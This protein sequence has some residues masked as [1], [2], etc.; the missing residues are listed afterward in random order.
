MKKNRLVILSLD[1]MV[2]ED[3]ETL[4]KYPCFGRLI[5]QGSRVNRIRTIYPSLTYP[6]HVSILTGVRPGR[7]G[8]VNNEPSIPGNLKC[9][10]YW[11]HEPVRSRDLH[12]AAKEAGLRTASIFWPASGSHP[13]VDYL[14]A[15]YWAQS[16]EDTLKAAYLRAGT[17]EELFESAVLPYLEGFSSWESPISDEAKICAACDIIKKYKPHL[18]TLHLGQIDYYR[19]RY[20]IFNDMVTK[21]VEQS[22]RYLQMLFDACTEAG[23]Y[24]KTNFVVLSDHGQINYT[25]HMNINLLLEREGL[26]HFDVDERLSSWDAWIKTANFSG[27]V[28]LREPGDK[29]LYD[30]VYRM[31]TQYCEEGN[32]GISRVYSAEEAREEEGLYGDFSFVVES[33]DTTLFSSDWR[34]PLF[35]PAQP[36]SPG[37][38]R[39]SHGHHPSKGP[40]PVFLA[41]G[42][43]IKTGIIIEKGQLIDEAPTFARLLDV[44]LPDTEGRV[45][46]EILIR[47]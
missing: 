36:E 43:D 12:D 14:L 33:D 15:E 28:Y 23:T 13:S 7:H 17:S 8:I 3:L 6:A 41:I 11:F 9:D 19:H 25:R 35:S 22:E 4:Q 45:M 37:Y 2:Y 26:L 16:K 46:E 5:H 34:E 27:Q 32:M 20:G 10:W 29:R 21:G 18:L 42:P 30:H 47:G 38:S 24:D 44:D 1:A 39:G 31:L 40:Q